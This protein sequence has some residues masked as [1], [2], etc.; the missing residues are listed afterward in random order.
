VDRGDCAGSYD[1]LDAGIQSTVTEDDWCTAVLP[2]LDANLDAHFTL[3]RAV[4]QGD[5]AEVEI[6]G[7]VH[8]TWRLR[9]FGERSWRVVGPESG[10]QFVAL[11]GEF[12]T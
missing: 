8:E 10:F 11:E 6:S 4:L 1:L 2:S 9:R 7:V 5:V 3:E 12:G